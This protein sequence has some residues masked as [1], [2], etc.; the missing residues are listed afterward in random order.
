MFNFNGSLVKPQWN[1]EN[2]MSKHIPYKN[3]QSLIP[4]LT[5]V[6]WQKISN[7]SRNKSL[8]LNVSRRVMQLPLPNPMKPGVKSIMKM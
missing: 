2:W 8:N 3:M 5:L 4:I 1:L 7:I 6:N